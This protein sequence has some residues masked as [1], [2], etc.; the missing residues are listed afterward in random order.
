MRP[1][2]RA[3]LI[4]V[5][6]A[7]GLA[8]ALAAAGRRPP[9]APP[10]RSSCGSGTTQDLDSLNPYQTPL[11]VGYEVV[12]AQLQPAGRLRP[13]TSSRCPGFADSWER[14]AGRQ[15]WTFHIRT[16]MKWSDGAAGDLGRRVLLAGSSAL[17][18]IEA[19]DVEHRRSAISTR[20]SRTPASPRSSAPT[21][22][23]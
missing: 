10:T 16:G 15:S 21:T 13:R 17:D 5:L 1:S 9:A 7:V 14:A 20:T 4:R 8:A 3:R 23:R 6:A 2:V 19:S 12:P 22:R 11:V 18:A